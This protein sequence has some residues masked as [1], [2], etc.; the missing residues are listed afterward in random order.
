MNTT[1]KAVFALDNTQDKSSGQHHIYPPQNE[2]TPANRL[3]IV[4][5]GIGLEEHTHTMATIANNTFVRLLTGS[6]RLKTERLGQVLIND[7]LRH[8]EREAQKYLN[9]YPR[10]A[11]VYGVV[12]LSHF[13]AD[14]SIT[15]AWVGNCRAYHIRQGRILYQTEDHVANMMMQDR[16]MTVPRGINGTEPA[17]A[18]VSTITNIQ[19]GDLLLL[20]TPAVVTA[21]SE[22]QLAEICTQATD[23]QALYQSIAA[24]LQTAAEPEAALFVVQIENSV[25]A[26]AKGNLQHAN[27]NLSSYADLFHQSTQS[28][29]MGVGRDAMLKAGIVLTAL[30]VLAASSYLLYR[31]FS[32][33]PKRMV[34]NLISEAQA[35]ASEG[36]YVKA[37]TDLEKALSIETSDTEALS[38]AQYMLQKMRQSIVVTQ[39]DSLF[40]AGEFFEAKTIYE[41]AYTMDTDNADVQNKVNQIKKL[42]DD[43]KKTRLKKAD[44]L[45]T[46][47]DY[48]SARNALLEALFYDQNNKRILEKIN[49]CNARLKED[50]L[51]AAN[52]VKR[53]TS[54]VRSLKDTL[55]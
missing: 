31:Y 34:N 3:F 22:E 15:L 13:N 2:A 9:Q 17:W 11:G 25:L 55:K 33:Q 42:I 46:A 51:S 44:S 20:C 21:T 8:A 53:A 28:K 26:N 27:N 41:R 16:V 18:S 49:E 7:A 45:Y 23:A 47:K 35:L 39:G 40:D 52:A 36:N 6:A 54:Y 4:S 50:T 37:I 48:A 5:A 14:G 19:A 10:L 32:N 1:I 29:T 43:E 30:L 12:A 38:T 24:K